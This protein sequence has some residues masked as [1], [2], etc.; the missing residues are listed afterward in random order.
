MI[1][2]RLSKTKFAADLTG[3]GARL[4]GGRW[5]HLLTACLYTA[6]SRSLAVLEYTV[7]VNIDD[8]PRAL[9]FVALQVPDSSID[10][11]NEAE[12]PGD[13]KATPAPAS[14]RDFGTNWLQAAKNLVMKVPSTVVREEWN[15]I[16]NPLHPGIKDCK[17][18]SV[19][20]FVYDVRIKLK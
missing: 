8:I 9:S 12:L 20:D 5:N 13:W 1:V 17:I 16:I 4:N 7:N 10:I 14:T 15:V 11:Y 3:E 18:I 6:E 2:Y 19:N